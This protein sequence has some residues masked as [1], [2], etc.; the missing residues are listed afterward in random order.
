MNKELFCGEFIKFILM[1]FGT[2]SGLLGLFILLGLT[3]ID[4]I[5]LSIVLLLF[6]IG[7]FIVVFNNRIYDK[8]AYEPLIKFF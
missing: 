3:L 2:I 1:C 7:L 8:F 5:F 4:N 6:G